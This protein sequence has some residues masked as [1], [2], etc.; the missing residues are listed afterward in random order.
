MNKSNAHLHD[1]ADGGILA[2]ESLELGL[3]VAPLLAG[4]NLQVGK[5][6]NAKTI[7]SNEGSWSQE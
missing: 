1:H 2:T 7:N 5:N 4:T 6:A 3:V